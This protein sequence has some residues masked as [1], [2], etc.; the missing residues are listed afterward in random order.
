MVEGDL[1]ENSWVKAEEC[2]PKELG[3]GWQTCS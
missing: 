3:S 1:K 2:N